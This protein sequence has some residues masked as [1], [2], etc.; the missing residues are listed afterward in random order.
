MEY[1]STE[2]KYEY[3]SGQ[4]SDPTLGA[5]FVAFYIVLLRIS[6]TKDK[7][8]SEVI[9]YSAPIFSSFSQCFV[10]FMQ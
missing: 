1:G 3:E 7:R 2:R 5:A 10:E 8:Q 4:G 9:K 6:S